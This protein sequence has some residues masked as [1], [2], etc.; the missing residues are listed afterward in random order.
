MVYIYFF[1]PQ[2]RTSYSPYRSSDC[3]TY[4]RTSNGT[5]AW[6]II[7]NDSPNDSPN[8]CPN[9]THILAGGHF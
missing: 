7:S 5:K 6:H 8:G 4:L 3:R 1:R 9:K 2:N